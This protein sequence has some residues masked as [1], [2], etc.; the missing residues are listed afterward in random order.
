MEFDRFRG[1]DNSSVTRGTFES[2]IGRDNRRNG[3]LPMTE[4]A[5]NVR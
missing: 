1:A 5:N 3:G 2:Y 4:I